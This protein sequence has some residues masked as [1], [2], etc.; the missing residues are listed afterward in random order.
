MRY[1]GLVVELLHAWSC[2][3]LMT[4]SPLLGLHFDDRTALGDAD[5]LAVAASNLTRWACQF[6]GRE[7]EVGKGDGGGNVDDSA[8][9][10]GVG[11]T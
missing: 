3:V 2:A 11:L 6:R 7:A 5:L 8:I 9:H 10:L 4:H 1:D